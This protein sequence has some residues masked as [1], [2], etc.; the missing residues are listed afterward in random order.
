MALSENIKVIDIAVCICT[1]K[2]P[3]SLK[4][5]LDSMYDLII[6]SGINFRIIV[7][8]NDTENFC[9]KMIKELSIRNKL[10]IYYYLE[11]RQGIVYARN[12]SVAEA[13]NCDFCCFTDDDQVVSRD[14]LIELLRCQHEF[15]SDGVT[16]P[17]RPI[18]TGKVPAYIQQFHQPDIHPYGTIVTYAFTGC[19]L[20]KKE[21][22][23]ML[24]GPFDIRFNFSGG[25]DAYL[26]KII[27]GLGGVIRYNPNAIAYENISQDRETVNFIVK[28]VFRRSNAK[29]LI[30]SIENKGNKPIKELPLL[31]LRFFYGLILVV[32]CFMFL[33]EN[34]LK[35]LIKIVNAIGG[36]SFF[37]GKLS[38][39]YKD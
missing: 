6:P 3:E 18:F 35:G 11:S 13:G 14:W 1:R 31:I 34:K 25:E 37:F 5:L 33:K 20:L 9:E 2:R 29:M 8:E 21:I 36:F 27:A 28:R 39:F 26:T 17:T 19:L 30:N 4:K 23:D 24:E 15:N 38:R 10:K 12:R 32:P 16:G 22:L 7:V